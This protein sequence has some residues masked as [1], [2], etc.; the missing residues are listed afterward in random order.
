MTISDCYI[1]LNVTR[2]FVV[3]LTYILNIHSRGQKF[4]DTSRKL[5][6]LSV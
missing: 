6:N 5:A 2:I 1:H 4:P 3:L